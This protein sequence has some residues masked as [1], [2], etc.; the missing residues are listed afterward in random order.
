MTGIMGNA[1]HYLTSK[2]SQALYHTMIYLY[3]NYCCNNIWE[4]TYPTRRLFIFKTQRKIV[5]SIL[6]NTKH[7]SI[8]HIPDSRL[9]VFIL[10]RQ[11]S[12][13]L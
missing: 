4:S 5:R 9:H 2:T 3:L 1:R 7:L 6:K 10:P 11:A 13:I 12:T 8:K